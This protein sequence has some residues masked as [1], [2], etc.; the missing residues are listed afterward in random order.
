MPSTVIRLQR[1]TVPSASI[2]VTRQWCQR[3]SFIRQRCRARCIRSRHD[4]CHQRPVRIDRREVPTAPKAKFLIDLG[5]QMIV[6]RLR[7]TVLVRYAA[8]VMT[9]T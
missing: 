6:G 8:R 3:S 7:R 9:R 1:V 5:L 2:Q 4:L